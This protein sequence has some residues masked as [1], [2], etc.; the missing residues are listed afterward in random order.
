MI[1]FSLSSLPL[2]GVGGGQDSF[3]TY[4]YNQNTYFIEQPNGERYDDESESIARRSDGSRK[5]E[6]AYHCMT[7]VLTHP[8]CLEQSE[9][10][11]KP[12][13]DRNLED[14]AE[15]ETHHHHRV[16]VATDRQHI[17]HRLTHLI[18]A[19]K[20]H[21]EWK[22]DEVVDQHTHK[23]HGVCRH[24]DSHRIAPFVLVESRSDEAKQKVENVGRGNEDAHHQRHLEVNH[25]LLRK[26]R[27]DE[28]DGKRFASQPSVGDEVTVF[29]C[30]HDVEERFL[31]TESSHSQHHRCHHH[32]DDATS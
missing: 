12:T 6:D 28:V 17:A 21:R 9:D 27:V 5:D 18:R 30:K 4:F 32:S 16:D 23:K 13:D 14:D 19:K 1:Y 11:E 31:Q 25:E 15:D 7:A 8:R 10:G 22:D 20:A 24:R 26:P 2:G 3:F 29:G